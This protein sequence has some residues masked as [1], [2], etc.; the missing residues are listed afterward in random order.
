MGRLGCHT[1]GENWGRWSPCKTKSLKFSLL[2]DITPT[3]KLSLPVPSLIT[4]HILEK[5]VAI[6]HIYVTKN[7]LYLKLCGYVFRILVVNK[8]YVINLLGL[9]IPSRT[10]KWSHNEE[11]PMR[12][13]SSSP[14]TTMAFWQHAGYGRPVPEFMQC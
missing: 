10:V 6:F 1:K 3:K 5:K 11:N 14:I 7:I 4:D 9:L 12:P 13:S 8:A 2:F